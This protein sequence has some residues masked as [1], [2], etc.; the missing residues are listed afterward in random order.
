MPVKYFPSLVCV[1]GY[2]MSYASGSAMGTQGENEIEI[3]FQRI[4]NKSVQQS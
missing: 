1:I 3:G 2:T 4:N